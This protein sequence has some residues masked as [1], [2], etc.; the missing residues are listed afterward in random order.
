MTKIIE[1]ARAVPEKIVFYPQNSAKT[2]QSR[3]IFSIISTI[4]PTKSFKNLFFGLQL[5]LDLWCEYLDY[6]WHLR[7]VEKLT[8]N[9]IRFELEKPSVIFFSCP[10][11]QNWSC[12]AVT[13]TVAFVSL[14]QW[15]N[16]SLICHYSRCSSRAVGQGTP[17]SIP[18]P[19]QWLMQM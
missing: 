14:V 9:R 15:T 18:R 16:R 5:I 12:L 8:L 1:I 6:I 7:W 10:S 2:V 19:W 4:F 13:W 11:I 3:M 17:C